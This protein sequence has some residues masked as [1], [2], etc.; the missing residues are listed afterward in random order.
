MGKILVFG[1]GGGIGA[2]VVARLKG[3]SEAQVVVAGRNREAQAATG[4]DQ[5]LVIDDLLAANAID[6]AFSAAEAE[7]A[8]TGVVAAVG[9][10]LLKPA[11]ATSDADFD[12]TIARNLT[13]AFRVL[14][15]AAK[16]RETLKSLVLFS[17]AAASVGLPNHEAIAAAKAGIEGLVRSAAAT[18]AGAGLRVNAVAPG[19]VRTKLAGRITGN[20]A[21]LAA[22]T[23]MHPLG[24]IGEVDDVAPVVTWLLSAES[25]WVTGQIIAVDGGLSALRAR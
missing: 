15:A 12:D 11:H 7:G 4:A 19:L 5:N 13:F 22:S 2:A 16:R 20:P 8:I 1:G 6:D 10:I 3:R 24:R 21:A 17:S 14:R 18:Y 25:S 9:S 23:A